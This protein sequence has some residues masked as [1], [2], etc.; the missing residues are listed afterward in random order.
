MYAQ[1]FDPEGSM[2]ADAFYR[3][4]FGALLPGAPGIVVL[5]NG[6]VRGSDGN[7]I[8]SGTYSGGE[9]PIEVLLNVKPIQADAPSV[10]GT[11]GQQFKLNLFGNFVPGGFTL[12]GSSPVQGGLGVSIRGTKV[13]EVG[14]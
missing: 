1:F 4:E 2:M 8:Y 13:S 9:G 14:F 6:Q 10:F 5:E 3:V 11:V 7:Y 12:A